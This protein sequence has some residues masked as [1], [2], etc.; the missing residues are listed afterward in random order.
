MAPYLAA[1]LTGGVLYFITN[2]FP[3][4]DKFQGLLI[5]ISSAFFSIPLLFIFYETTQ[6]FSNKRRYAPIFNYAK[7]Q[8]HGELTSILN[9]LQKIIFQY[10]ENGFKQIYSLDEKNLKQ[11]LHE[12]SFIGFQIFKHWEISKEH[13]ENFLKDPLILNYLDDSEISTIVEALNNLQMLEFFQNKNNLFLETG[14]ISKDY[15]IQSGVQIEPGNVE[16]PERYLLLKKLSEDRFL[17]CDF[18]DISNF[19]LKNCLKCYKVNPELVEDYSIVIFKVLNNI[20]KWFR[21]INF[22]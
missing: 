7:R 10:E 3:M 15:K 4:N 19:N 20:H 16:F 11:R 8:V 18:G 22:K 2:V 17:V 1:I 5:N 13:L 9:Q 12:N 14:V 6:N 21:I